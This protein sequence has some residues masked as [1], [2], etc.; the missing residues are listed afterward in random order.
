M[1]GVAA[2][3]RG[4]R[5]GRFLPPRPTEE[6]RK[7]G[8]PEDGGGDRQRTRRDPLRLFRTP[9]HHA[10]HYTR[11]RA[12]TPGIRFE[13]DWLPL[14]LRRRADEPSR[15]TCYRRRNRTMRTRAR[16]IRIAYVRSTGWSPEAQRVNSGFTGR[17]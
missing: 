5:R 15:T 7:T 10:R 17:R 9:A 2:G 13:T 14:L 12:P 3:G 16:L 1:G 4:R 11:T 6:C 8:F